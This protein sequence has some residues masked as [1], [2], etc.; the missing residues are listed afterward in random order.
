MANA[1]IINNVRLTKNSDWK[2]RFAKVCTEASALQIWDTIN[3]DYVYGVPKHI[4]IFSMN[5]EFK[6][7]KWGHEPWFAT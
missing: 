3:R 1:S 7:R 6:Q 4:G 5:T 2:T